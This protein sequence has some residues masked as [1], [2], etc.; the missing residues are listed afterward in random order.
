MN[1]SEECLEQVSGDVAGNRMNGCHGNNPWLRM[2]QYAVLHTQFQQKKANT[3][4]Q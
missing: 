4:K 3:Q 1:G 2:G